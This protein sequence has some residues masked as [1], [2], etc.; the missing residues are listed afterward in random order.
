[1]TKDEAVA[2]IA[3]ATGSD[4]LAFLPK[5]VL[6]YLQAKDILPDTMVSVG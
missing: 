2:A 3:D 6:Q 1:M 5:S 4:E